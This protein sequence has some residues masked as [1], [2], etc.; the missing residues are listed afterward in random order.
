MKRDKRYF[1]AM[2]ATADTELLEMFIALFALRLGLLMVFPFISIYQGPLGDLRT[3]VSEP[4]LGSFVMMSSLTWF[5]GWRFR[6]DQMRQLSMM[7]LAG[8]YSFLGAILAVSPAGLSG[9]TIY[10]MVAFF[11]ILAYKR[12]SDG[13]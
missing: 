11:A 9:W 8:I 13:G 5:F 4:V 2:L 1:S 10:F 6:N 3:I 7:M 12:V